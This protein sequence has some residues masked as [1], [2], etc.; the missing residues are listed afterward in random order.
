MLAILFILGMLY[1]LNV[2][3]IPI[4]LM[5]IKTVFENI[6]TD[7]FLRNC[8]LYGNTN[9]TL[10]YS[11]ASA[12]ENKTLVLSCNAIKPNL[13][14]NLKGTQYSMWYQIGNETSQ[15]LIRKTTDV[16][17]YQNIDSGLEARSGAMV[18]ITVILSLAMVLLVVGLIIVIFFSN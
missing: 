6:F 2:A 13:L 5:D 1:P 12:T 18:V 11:E 3:G 9:A 10:L 14:Q 7:V 17:N 15:V 16:T 4:E 8:S